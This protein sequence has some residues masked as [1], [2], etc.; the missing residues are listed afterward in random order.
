MPAWLHRERLTTWMAPRLATGD[1]D[2]RTPPHGYEPMREG[3]MAAFARGW[4]AE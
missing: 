3:A 1:H 4:A 2:D